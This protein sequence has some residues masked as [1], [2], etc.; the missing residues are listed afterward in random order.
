MNNKWIAL[1]GLVLSIPLLAQEESECRLY[2]SDIGI[3]DFELNS[4]IDDFNLYKP[5]D[6]KEKEV[7]DIIAY[8]TDMESEFD[9]YPFR[10]IILP[11]NEITL[12]FKERLEI[13][14]E[15]RDIE[16][17]LHYE[18]GLLVKYL[19]FIY[20]GDYR[21]CYPFY[22]DLISLLENY[23]SKNIFI[24]KERLVNYYTIG[25]CKRIFSLRALGKFSSVL[26]GA[27]ILEL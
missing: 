5:S 1:L 19:V 10:K 2:F 8:A 7:T 6:F 21:E 13:L 26:I 3:Y 27:E 9:N 24:N 18:N 17:V 14:N 11:D 4:S 12:I 23:G 20:C 15:E 22:N 16:Y 25:N